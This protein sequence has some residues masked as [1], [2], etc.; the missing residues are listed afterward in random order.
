MTTIEQR[1]NL[2]HLLSQ[3]VVYGVPGD[4]VEVGTH[5]G[6]TAALFMTIIARLDSKR[7]LHLFDVFRDPPESVVR[8]HFKSLNLPE[9][10]I[11]RGWLH[12]TLPAELP[13]QIAFFN[14]DLGP[15]RSPDTFAGDIGH[16][17]AAIYPRM[18]PGAVG[19]LQDYCDPAA[20]DR[21]GY[22]FPG[23]I[24]S[25]KYWN[26]YPQVKQACDEFFRDKPEKV[27]PLFAGNYSHGY[28][29]KQGSP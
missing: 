28:F 4:A 17:L 11:H 3:V 25:T 8:E 19:V 24:R 7:T 20:Y 27:H 2:F 6:V 16:A 15:G 22:H 14:L 1:I 23:L 12:E 29:R 5:E 9:P 18:T 10:I 26:H 13:E 21:P